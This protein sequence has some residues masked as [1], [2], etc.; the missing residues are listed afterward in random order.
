MCWKVGEKVNEV[1]EIAFRLLESFVEVCNCL[2][3]R[4]YL[5]HGSALGAIKYGGFIPWDDDVDIAMPRKD[6]EIFCADGQQ[7]LPNHIAI[8]NYRTNPDFIFSFTQ[9]RDVNTTCV[10]TVT[11]HLQIKFGIYIDIFPLDGY[12]DDEVQQQYVGRKM[13]N[14][15][16]LEFCGLRQNLGLKD[17]VKNMVL[18][19]AGYHKRTAS[20]IAKIEKVITQYGEDTTQWRDYGDRMYQ[21]GLMPR[22]VYGSGY[23]C[24]FE[25]LEV[26]VPEKYDE[27]LTRKYGDWRSDPPLDQQKSHHHHVALDAHRPYTEYLPLLREKGYRK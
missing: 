21:K 9:L 8:E 20:T 5:V 3:L 12:P 2:N 15:R 4:W 16:R 14:L 27:Y 24:K 26:I 6:Y 13:K 18:R 22:E 10:D 7:Y 25:G 19:A 23:K 11:A 17:S 1:Q